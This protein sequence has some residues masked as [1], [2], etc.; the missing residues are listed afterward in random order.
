MKKILVVD[1]NANVR[2][3]L[4]EYLSEQGYSVLHAS[5]GHEAV[6][7]LENQHPDLILLDVMMPKL[8]GYQTISRIRR[9]NAIPII[10]LTAKRHESDV[11]RGFELG[12]DD[13]IIKPFQMRELLM[14]IRA[15]MRRATPQGSTDSTL[16]VGAISLD[17]N[18]RRVTVF[19][20]PVELTPLELCLLARLIAL[21]EHT[22]HRAEL[23]THLIEHGFTGSEA[24]LKIH[25]RNLRS[26][27]ENDPSKP[28]FIETVFGV[29]YRLREVM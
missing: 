25:I 19:G 29:G 23:S 2:R 5:D 6:E 3:L 14:R 10:M 17:Q 21:A 27:I 24:T 26:K 20:N 7:A 9:L 12:A 15:V 16:T 8:D 4:Q 22:L 28:R 18:K 11:V 13:Y 1:D